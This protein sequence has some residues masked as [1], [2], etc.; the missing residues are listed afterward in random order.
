ME[1]ADLDQALYARMRWNT[2]LS[3][4]HA[5]LLMDRLD[6][7]AGLRIVDL[8]LSQRLRLTLAPPSI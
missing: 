1:G 3:A 7:R 5:E 8:G 2:P 6:L 4:E